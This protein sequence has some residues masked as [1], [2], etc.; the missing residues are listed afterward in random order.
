M[1]AATGAGQQRSYTDDT[2][3]MTRLTP[4]RSARPE[5]R[6]RSG[7]PSRPVSHTREEHKGSDSHAKLGVSEETLVSQT[8]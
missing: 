7:S 6:A 1:S 4:Q 3:L 5:N 2:H 8:L